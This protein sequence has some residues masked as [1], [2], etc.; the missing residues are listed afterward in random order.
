ME[1]NLIIQ[2]QKAVAESIDRETLI[3]KILFAEK[4]VEMAR[5]VRQN[6]SIVEVIE[7]ITWHIN[8]GRA[9]SYDLSTTVNY[10]I[11][12]LIPTSRISL[13]C[14]Q[15]DFIFA[16]IHKFYFSYSI[17]LLLR[18]TWKCRAMMMMILWLNYTNH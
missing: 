7:V 6:F 16:A 11:A 1:K 3:H 15:R 18:T 2:E 9:S 5:H 12:E 14:H 13:T 8:D 17:R 10:K 4:V